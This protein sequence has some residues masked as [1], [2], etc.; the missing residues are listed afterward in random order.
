MPGFD[1]YHFSMTKTGHFPV[2]WKDRVAIM[3]P[4]KGPPTVLWFT[5]VPHIQYLRAPLA[6]HASYWHE[7]FGNPKSAE[8]VNVAPEDAK[9]LFDFTLPA[10]PEGWG[11]MRPGDGN[12]PGTPIVSTAL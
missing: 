1:P 3:S 2:E 5:D 10:L 9:W 6:M 7:D 11:G 4:D 8:C 12:G